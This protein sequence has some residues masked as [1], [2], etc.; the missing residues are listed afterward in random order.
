MK[1][2]SRSSPE[3]LVKNAYNNFNNMPQATIIH[4]VNKPKLVFKTPK[5]CNPIYEIPESIL[6]KKNRHRHI[7]EMNFVL[8]QP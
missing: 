8:A 1:H 3:K 7:F 6:D 5:F 4:V 2:G